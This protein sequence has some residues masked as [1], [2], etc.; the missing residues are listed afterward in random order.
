MYKIIGKENFFHANYRVTLLP[1][2][3]GAVNPNSV[4]VEGRE[5]VK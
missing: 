5:V 2:Y 4:V 1:I 3:G